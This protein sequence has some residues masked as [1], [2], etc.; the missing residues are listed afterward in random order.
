M[1]W[2][3][4]G[5]QSHVHMRNEISHRQSSCEGA[6]WKRH[7]GCLCF[8][9]D[10]IFVPQST[11]NCW[12]NKGKS[13]MALTVDLRGWKCSRKNSEKWEQLSYTVLRNW[14]SNWPLL[15]TST[16]PPEKLKNRA[17][18]FLSDSPKTA[19]RESEFSFGSGLWLLRTP[20]NYNG[21]VFNS[22][23]FEI[24]RQ[25]SCGSKET[26]SWNHWGRVQFR[27]RK[28]GENSEV[29]QNAHDQNTGRPSTESASGA[30]EGVRDEGFAFRFSWLSATRK[31]E[32]SRTFSLLGEDGWI[33][34]IQQQ[35]LI[36]HSW[37]SWRGGGKWWFW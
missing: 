5:G 25:S 33:T 10:Y 21:Q 26:L 29:L 18:L 20:P 6:F 35:G 16:Y 7:T 8:C 17:F 24:P 2:K 37:K 4:A 36:D 19:A 14:C 11:L 1:A 31:N 22:P 32:C 23:S 12:T 13:M 34:Q 28:S 9:D 3:V 15:P 27:F 30:A